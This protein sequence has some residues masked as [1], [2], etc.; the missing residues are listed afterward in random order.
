MGKLNC[1]SSAFQIHNVH[2]IKSNLYFKDSKWF[3]IYFQLAYCVVQFLEK[4]AALTEDVRKHY[5]WMLYFK[6]NYIS[7]TQFD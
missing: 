3:Y 5:L 2:K 7:L 1:L 4:D 6:L